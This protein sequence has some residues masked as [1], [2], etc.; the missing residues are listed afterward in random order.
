MREIKFRAWDKSIGRWITGMLVVDGQGIVYLRNPNTNVIEE[1][2]TL[3]D[4]L[5]LVW[6]TGL[7][8]KTG[9]EIYEGDIVELYKYQ[10]EAL[11]CLALTIVV[12]WCETGLNFNIWPPQNGKELWK[13]VGNIYENPELQERQ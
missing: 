1:Q 6:Y 13:V 11:Y 4:D 12:K 2:H 9:K 8:D 5:A 3:F 10:G 7:K